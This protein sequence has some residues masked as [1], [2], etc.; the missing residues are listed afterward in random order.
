MKVSGFAIA[1]NV[2]Q[3]DYPLKEAILSILPLCDEIVIAVGKSQDNT[4]AYI[5]SFNIPQLRIID[6]VWNDNIREG[7]AVLADETNKAIAEVAKD[8]DW[9]IYIQADE[10]IHEDDL[11]KIRKAME[12]NLDKKHVDGLLFDYLHFYGSYE[13]LG[14]SRRWYKHEIRIIRNN[15][16]IKSWKDA[17]GFR[18]KDDT[19]ITVANANGRI[20][21]Y[22]WV[23]HPKQQ[24]IKQMQFHRLWHDDAYMQKNVNIS[25]EF[26]YSN[27]DSLI[28]FEQT[29]P[30][31]MKNRVDNI[32]WK[33]AMNPASKKF[34]IKAK[35]LY[36]IEKKFG[37]RVGEYKNYKLVK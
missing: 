15:L 10:C 36:W 34:G 16:G 26:D 6:T 25:D 19:K 8:S 2:V 37:W 12:D 32:S 7:G 33:F 17:Q 27:I 20:F 18:K 14:D 21:H 30:A 31:V 11:P 23:K 28:P 4:R 35:L 9:L 1:R 29:H 13:F 22:G 3:A 24:Q 5:E